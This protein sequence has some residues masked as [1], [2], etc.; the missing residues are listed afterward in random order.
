MN[1]RRATEDDLTPIWQD[2]PEPDP[3]EPWIIRIGIGPAPGEPNN[4][5]LVNCAGML[6]TPEGLERMRAWKRKQEEDK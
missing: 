3:N 6:M 1:E 4:A 2:P 5:G